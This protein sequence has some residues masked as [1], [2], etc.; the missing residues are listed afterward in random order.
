MDRYIVPTAVTSK[1]TT[2]KQ[3]TNKKNHTNKKQT[4]T[5]HQNKKNNS[6]PPQNHKNRKPTA[7]GE[8]VI[9]WPVQQ[10]RVMSEGVIALYQPYLGMAVNKHK[11]RNKE[12]PSQTSPHRGKAT[13]HYAETRAPPSQEPR[14]HIEQAVQA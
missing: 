2:N 1:A 7:Q 6:T 5:S 10:C 3:Q 9:G 4:Q 12:K 13:Q 14:D 8:S 11:H